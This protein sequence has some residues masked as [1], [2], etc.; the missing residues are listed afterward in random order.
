MTNLYSFGMDPTKWY[1]RGLWASSQNETSWIT[2]NN[3]VQGLGSIQTMA[4]GNSI[5]VGATNFG[6]FTVSSDLVNW[7]SYTPENKSWLVN[8]ATWGQGIFCVVGHEKN[9]N[10]LS[11]TGFIAVSG[12]GGP[13]TWTRKY[14]SYQEPMTL[15]DIKHYGAGNWIAVGS[16][17]NLSTL[18]V[19]V[20]TDNTDTWTRVT[21]PSILSTGI[22]SVEAS[23][24][25]TLKVWLGGK[26]W[27]AYTPNFQQNNT[28]WTLFDQ[29]SDQ[30]K[31]KPISRI[32]YR[33]TTGK[34]ATVALTGGTI[35]FTD[36]SLNWKSQTQEGYRFQDAANF[37]NPITQTESFYFSVGGMMNQYT[38]FK[39]N[40][41]STSS[42]PFSLEGYNNGVQATS[43]IVV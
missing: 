9:F 18:V 35:W 21:L 39:T 32:L 7:F 15:F 1:S 12:N 41:Q 14:V 13:A 25:L 2:G 23:Q 27:I 31:N 17:N 33:S 6:D 42:S 20:S 16:T 11:E 38:G 28:Q 26:G 3:P 5:W 34:Q 24:G 29:L 37:Q 30:G 36:N 10:N 19:L 40:W 43:F 8:K 22:Y 4:Y